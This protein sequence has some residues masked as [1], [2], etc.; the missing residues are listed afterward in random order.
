[1]KE[2]LVKVLN[3]F[4]ALRFS[5]NIKAKCQHGDVRLAGT[6][7]NTIGRIEVC[8]NGTWGTVHDCPS[9]QFSVAEAS[10]VC[11][12]LG[13]SPYG[14]YF[15][16]QLTFLYKLIGAIP[17]PG[18]FGG[19]STSSPIIYNLDCTGEENNLWACS[20]STYCDYLSDN[21]I[22][23]ECQCEYSCIKN[24]HLSII[25]FIRYQ[26]YCGHIL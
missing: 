5:L 10:I 15:V 3:C 13:Y 6:N 9:S 7:Y 20:Y 14:N 17:R 12:H 11:K 21:I 26:L 8:Q 4:F 25:Y 23:V 18:S 1:M 19:Y 24:D 22:A 2:L 16:T